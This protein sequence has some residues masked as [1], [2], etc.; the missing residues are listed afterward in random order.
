[1]KQFVKTNKPQ[2]HIELTEHEFV[3]SDII[4]MMTQ[5]GTKYILTCNNKSYK[6]S[7]GKGWYSGPSDRLALFENCLYNGHKLFLF[8]SLD[9]LADWIKA[10]K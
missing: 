5:N 3:D 1:M 7:N 6:F 2:S 9:E 4:G 10:P 8:E